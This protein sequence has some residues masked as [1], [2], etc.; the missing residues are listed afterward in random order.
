MVRH[1][2]SGSETIGPLHADQQLVD[3]NNS[4]GTQLGHGSF[5]EDIGQEEFAL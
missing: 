4:V 1:R 2:S 5:T 3:R